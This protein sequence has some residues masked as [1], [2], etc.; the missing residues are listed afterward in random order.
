LYTGN[1]S[2]QSI[3][4]VGF[5][6]D[7]VWIKERSGSEHHSLYDAVRGATKEIASNRTNVE[8]TVA[9]SL[10]GFDSDGFTL[11]SWSRT[12]NNSDTFA[13]WNWK[14]GTT[15]S[16]TTTGSGE[17]RAY[18]YSVNTTAGFSIITYK[19]NG[20]SGH[21][22]PHHLGVVPK[23]IITKNRDVV[24]NWRVYHASLGATKYLDLNEYSA[25]GTANSRWN[26]TEPTSTVFTVGT[27]S[28][29]NGNTVSGGNNMI[30][31]CF[32]EK[33]GYSKFGS[34]TGNGSTD[35]TFVYTGFKPKF[36]L[37]KRTDTGNSYDN[38]YLFDNKRD[39]F[40]PHNKKIEANVDSTE[41]SDTGLFDL[42]SNGFKLRTTNSNNNG[43]GGTF[44]YM[45]IG[46]SLVG[47]NGVTAKAR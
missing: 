2:T 25:V 45:A 36:I 3:T 35:G 26:D 5:Q 20:T 38:W 42:L 39:G 17:A 24:Q 27:N 14:A 15:G 11:G 10:T 34:Y 13:S 44:I 9:T 33:T 47:S 31:Y 46:Q 32:A 6:P 23:M 1:S 22:I 29:T 7:W 43:S 4:G 28:G 37:M 19:G 40:N 41:S 30:A 8:S 12:N 18:S 16:G 21:Q